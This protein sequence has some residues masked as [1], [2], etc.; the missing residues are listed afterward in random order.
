MLK[1]SYY[2]EPTELDTQVFDTLVPRD[3]YLRQLLA[4][5][6]FDALAAQLRLYY[7]PDRGR[8][9][10]DPVQLLKLL[11]LQ[12]IYDRSD[13][14]VLAEAQVNVAYRYFLQLS[15]TSPLPT[16]GLLAQFRQRLGE[17]GGRELLETLLRQARAAGLV[18]DRLR[19]RDTTHII[20]DVAIPAPLTLVAQLRQRL[21]QVCE[22]YA[23]TWVAEQQAHAATLRQT[24][25]DQPDALR[26]AQR[27]AHLQTLVTWAQQLQTRLGPAA[28]TDRPR[29]RL[30][31]AVTLAQQILVQATAPALPDQVRSLHDPD[32]RRGWHRDYYDGYQLDVLVDA[33]SE[34][35]TQVDI[36][37]ANQAEAANA[38]PLIRREEAAHHVDIAAL[39][40]DKSGFNGASL[41]E[42][43][44]PDDL[45]LVVYVPPQRWA[46][47]EDTPYYHP[48]DFRQTADGR[49]LTCPAG[50]TCTSR[51]RNSKDTGWQFTYPRA[52]CAAC[53]LQAQCLPRLP[54]K[55]GRRV[56]KNDYEAEYA[57]ARARAQTPAYTQVRRE[58]PLVER[59]LGEVVRWH[60][61]RRARY[62]GRA[63][64]ALQYLLAVFVVNARRLVQLLG[65]PAPGTPLTGAPAPA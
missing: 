47:Y 43:T 14:E 15:L 40:A 38:A 61:G 45:N 64:V 12:W 63:R 22:P 33:D 21:L 11:L 39:S 44:A 36:Q 59:K 23:A 30:D 48:P 51:H 56:I 28:P 46:T 37:P 55:N 8:P 26:L 62:R 52:T 42:L 13:R 34:L 10:L 27:V 2:S 5:L 60:G 3:H 53:P 9:A 24:T 25:A 1:E 50:Q 16:H 35:I 18:K 7:T 58:H 31:A 19:L 17:T 4:V 6:D 65:G 29:A 49:G 57:A 20:A 54:Q 41:R 32:A